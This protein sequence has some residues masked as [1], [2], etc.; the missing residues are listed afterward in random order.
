M[1]AIGGTSGA[2][3]ALSFRS[4]VNPVWPVIAVLLVAGAVGTARMLLKKHDL[5]QVIAGYAVGFTVLYL[6]I[7]F[8]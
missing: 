1:A 3:F 4:G 2:L 6:S 8:V 5:W 7:Y